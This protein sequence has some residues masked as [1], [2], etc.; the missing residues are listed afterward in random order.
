MGRTQRLLNAIV[1]SPDVPC[2]DGCLYI[3]TELCAI[4]VR[5]SPHGLSNL[6]P[7]SSENMHVPSAV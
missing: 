1:H 7:G 3:L 2:Y 6:A 5:T 4:L